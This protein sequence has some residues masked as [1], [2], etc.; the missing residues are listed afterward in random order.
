MIDK[1]IV[2]RTRPL[3]KY[4]FKFLLGSAPPVAE[5]VSPRIGRGKVKGSILGR[6]YRPNRSE[7]SVVFSDTR[8]KTG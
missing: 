8:V 2:F 3:I 6:T 5:L 1:I 4:A 7:F